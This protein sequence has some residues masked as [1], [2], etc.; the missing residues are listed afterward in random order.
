ME[1]KK[2][3]EGLESLDEVTMARVA[4]DF[5]QIESVMKGMSSD[6]KLIITKEG[7]KYHFSLETEG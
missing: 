2:L 4:R 7:N 6:Q 5:K 3:V 1:I